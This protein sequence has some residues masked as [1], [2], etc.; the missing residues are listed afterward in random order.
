MCTVGYRQQCEHRAVVRQ[1]IQ[2]AGGDGRDAVEQA[3][4]HAHLRCHCHILG[5]ERL[6]RNGHTTR[7]RTS[8]TGQQ[9]DCHSLREQDLAG[10]VQRDIGQRSKAGHRLDDRAEAYCTSGVHNRAH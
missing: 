5:T 4:I 9:V 7:S 6:Q 1:G 10:H 3:G 2:T 8:R